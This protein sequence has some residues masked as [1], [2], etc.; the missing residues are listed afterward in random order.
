MI[1]ITHIK[2]EDQVSDALTKPFPD[3]LFLKQKKK[4]VNFKIF[5]FA[6]KVQ[7]MIGYQ[8]N[9]LFVFFYLK[10]KEEIFSY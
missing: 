3:I 8:E 9:I 6:K 7:D 2:T 10:V 4:C 5:F 1:E